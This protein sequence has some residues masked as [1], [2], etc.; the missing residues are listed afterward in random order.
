MPLHGWPV[1]GGVA[2]L[3]GAVV[4]D[5][6]CLAAVVLIP[7]GRSLVPARRKKATLDFSASPLV[8]ALNFST[9]IKA[10]NEKNKN[11][12]SKESFNNKMD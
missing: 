4:A 9:L 11:K 10:S 6:L 12:N 1:A 8:F 7:N 5:M 3:F 2:S